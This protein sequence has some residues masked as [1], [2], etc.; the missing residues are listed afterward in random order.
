MATVLNYIIWLVTFGKYSPF[1]IEKQNNNSDKNISDGFLLVNLN[2]SSLFVEEMYDK[3]TESKYNVLIM[4]QKN[5]PSKKL[6]LPPPSIQNDIL[7]YKFNLRKKERPIMR[8][9]LKP[10][11]KHDIIINEIKQKKQ[12]KNALIICLDGSKTSF[13]ENT[14]DVETKILNSKLQKIR[15]EKPR[16]ILDE[17]H[18]GVKLRKI[19]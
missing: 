15:L 11:N 18:E 12:L 7:N 8:E 9:P 10:V 19:N 5:E 3:L 13:L 6:I 16:T 1:E 4:E 2:N 17:I 14:S